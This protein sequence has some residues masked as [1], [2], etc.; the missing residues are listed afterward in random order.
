MKKQHIHDHVGILLNI[1]YTPHRVE[2]PTIHDVH[3][4]DDN[5]R[6]VGPDLVPL[7]HGTL[8]LVAPGEATPF[9]SLVA[10]ELT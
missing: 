7:L 8:V 6:C 4:L 1:T 3:V 9:L 10:E 5:Y 2:G